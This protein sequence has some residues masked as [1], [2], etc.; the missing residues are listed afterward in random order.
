M[1]ERE[2]ALEILAELEQLATKQYVTAA[3]FAKI[4]IG[5]GEDDKA[6]DE[7]EKACNERAVR[8]AWVLVDPAFKH[9][10]NDDRYQEICRRSG[11]PEIK[12]I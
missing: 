5:L 12:P 1:G 8:L 10:H 11:L 3:N 4:Y 7:L 6:I 9:L 2:A